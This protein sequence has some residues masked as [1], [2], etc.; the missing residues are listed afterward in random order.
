[1]ERPESADLLVNATSVG[2]DHD[3]S[4]SEALAQLAL[5]RAE[6]APLVVD[7]VYGSEPTALVRWAERNGA[8]VVD[9]LEHLVRQG[10]R[11]L[12]GWIGGPAPL[13]AMRAA[14][15]APV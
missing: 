13:D 15:R 9:G 14:A 11:S 12:E 2:L 7:L 6:P 8:R 1:V 5:D 4:E 10:A 3:T